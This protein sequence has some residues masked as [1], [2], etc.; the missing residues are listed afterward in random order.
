M[1]IL[2]KNEIIVEMQLAIK[3]DKSKFIDCS[4][5]F[6]HYLYELQRA[7]FGSVMQMCSV[8]MSLDNRAQFYAQK[9]EK[10]NVRVKMQSREKVS[11]CCVVKN[12]KT[13]NKIINLPFICNY[14]NHHYSESGLDNQ[15]TR[16]NKC[17]KFCCFLCKF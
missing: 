5:K 9:K 11:E 2:Y 10:L 13:K 17:R 16:C 4:N 6:N 7:K 12:S 15:H 3:Q 8:W 14:C 1:N